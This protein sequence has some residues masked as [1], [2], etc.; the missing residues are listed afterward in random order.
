LWSVVVMDLDPEAGKFGRSK[1]VKVKVA[2]DVQPVPP[3]SNVPGYP[4]L[5][6]FTDLTATPY[7]DTNSCKGGR[8]PHKCR[9]RQAWSLRASGMVPAGTNSQAA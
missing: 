4:P 9:A 8:T 1:E 3:T 7:A 5:V 6:E 2:A